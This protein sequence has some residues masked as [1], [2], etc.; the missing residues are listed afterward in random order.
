M[1][2]GE[3]TALPRAPVAG[4]RSPR[5]PR[6]QNACLPL[7]HPRPI[8]GQDRLRPGGRDVPEGIKPCQ[9]WLGLG[10]DIAPTA[11]MFNGHDPR[12][13][14]RFACYGSGIGRAACGATEPSGL[15][16]LAEAAAGWGRRRRRIHKDARPCPTRRLRQGKAVPPGPILT[17]N[18]V[19]RRKF[20]ASETARRN[21][22]SVA[23]GWAISSL[24]NTHNRPRRGRRDPR[25]SVTAG[26]SQR[27]RLADLAARKP[28]SSLP[29]THSKPRRAGREGGLPLCASTHAMRATRHGP[30]VQRGRVQVK[31]GR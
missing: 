20:S 6:D 24:P 25:T 28:I 27:D 3:R 17:V 18:R 26:R 13:R 7:N 4:V 23:A 1:A 16:A 21:V 19:V 2:Q 10:I 9:R 22:V 30:C 31:N 15:L 12:R 11:P 5:K 14:C 8:E 29:N